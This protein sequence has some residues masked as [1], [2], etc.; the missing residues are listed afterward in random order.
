MGL[1]CCEAS[2]FLFNNNLK[3]EVNLNK[4]DVKD[5]NNQFLI[6][7]LTFNAKSSLQRELSR[8]DDVV[9]AVAFFVA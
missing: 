6:C 3:E 4:L 7:F 5:R 8:S 9:V 2:S 1:S